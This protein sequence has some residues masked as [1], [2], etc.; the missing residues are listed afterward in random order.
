MAQL[1]FGQFLQLPIRIGDRFCFQEFF[2]GLDLFEPLDERMERLLPVK[3]Q[4]AFLVECQTVL[5]EALLG[6]EEGLDSVN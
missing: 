3:D 4:C 6:L 1:Q 2:A 5:A